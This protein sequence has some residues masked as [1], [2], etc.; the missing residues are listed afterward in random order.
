MGTV[1]LAAIRKRI[2]SLPFSL[3]A[4]LM[5]SSIVPNGFMKTDLSIFG[6][7]LVTA[8]IFDQRAISAILAALWYPSL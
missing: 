5:A 1:M 6:F 8:H 4:V 7:R 3:T 2:F